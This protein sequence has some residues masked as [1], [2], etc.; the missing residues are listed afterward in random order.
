[1]FSK[2][3]VSRRTLFML[4]NGIVLHSDVASEMGLSF[5]MGFSS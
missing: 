4:Q 1:M 5:K 3:G 2:N